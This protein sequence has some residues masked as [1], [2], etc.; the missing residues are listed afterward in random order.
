MGWMVNAPAALASGKRP[1]THYMEAGWTPGPV[2]T[3]AEN[4]APPGFE[5]Q[6]VHSIV[7]RYTN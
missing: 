3:A 2:W 4:L 6:T 1:G 5:L 7:S